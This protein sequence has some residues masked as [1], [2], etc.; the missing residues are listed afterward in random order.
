[1]QTLGCINIQNGRVCFTYIPNQTNG[2]VTTAPGFGYNPNPTYEEVY[3][4]VQNQISVGEGNSFTNPNYVNQLYN[5]NNIL[6]ELLIN[7]D[8]NNVA[9]QTT[10]ADIYDSIYPFTTLNQ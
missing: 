8:V 6:A 4:L 1:M 9:F 7:G 5:Y 3:R 10:I 2:L